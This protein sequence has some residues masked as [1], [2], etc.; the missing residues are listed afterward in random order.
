ML[1]VKVNDRI[2]KAA[3]IVRQ[4]SKRVGQNGKEYYNLQISHG[5]KNYDAKIWNN[6]EEIAREIKP[7]CYAYITG[8][9]KDFKGMLQIH[10][11]NI[12]RIENPDDEIIKNVTPSSELNNLNAAKDIESII[13]TVKTAELKELLNMIFEAPE[14]KSSFY[15]KAAGAEI[16]HAFVGGLAQHT[17]EVTRIVMSYCSIYDYINYDMAVTAALLHDIGKTV[18]LSNF[19]ENKYTVRGRLLGHITIGVQ[20]IDSFI[21]RI[22]GFPPNLKLELEHCILSHHGTLEMGSPILPMTVEAAALHSA[23]AAS[24]ELNGF[25]LAIQRDNGTNAFTD[26]INAYKRYIKK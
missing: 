2:E 26:Y 3:V 14:I 20:I 17:L 24:A 12:Q 5:I 6:N 22:Q 13:D 21:S 11:E 23:D 7:G 18:E 1:N 10:I 25:Y 19:P 4:I 15:Q 8:T 9:V 16:H